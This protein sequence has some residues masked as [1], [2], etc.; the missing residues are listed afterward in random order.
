MIYWRN[1][2]KVFSHRTMS[3]NG[4]GEAGTFLF[5]LMKEEEIVGDVGNAE[6][7]SKGGGRRW[8][9][10]AER[11]SLAMAVFRRRPWPGI[12]TAL[13]S[14]KFCI[15]QALSLAMRCMSWCLARFMS[16]AVSVSDCCAAKR[17]SSASVRPERKK[18][19]QRGT[20]FSNSNGVA[21]RRQ[22]RRHL[23]F[24]SIYSSDTAKGR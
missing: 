17:A 22:T 7:F 15:D 9:T 11:P 19:T 14:S 10:G 20:S 13:R 24:G 2:R 8:E 1:R 4:D 6:A 16:S 3:L 5:C 18:S 21:H 12:S 23:P